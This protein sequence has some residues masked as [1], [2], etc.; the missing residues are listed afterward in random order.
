MLC[1]AML[2]GILLRLFI[3]LFV[4]CFSVVVVF[5]QNVYLMHPVSHTNYFIFGSWNLINKISGS[6]ACC[7]VLIK[8]VISSF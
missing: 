8:C 4:C 5:E 1:Y 7:V 3:C 2:N 6:C